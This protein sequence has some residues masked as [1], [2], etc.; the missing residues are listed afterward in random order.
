MDFS[1]YLD[2]VELEK[3]DARY[4]HSDEVFSRTIYINTENGELG[5]LS[6]YDLA[7]LGVP[8][9]RNSL[10]KGTAFAPDNIRQELYKLISPVRKLRVIDLGNLKSGNTYND[11]YFALKEIIFKLLCNN[12]VV[13]VIGGSQDLTLPIFQAFENYQEKISLVV[14]DSRIDAHGSSKEK[15]DSDSY[16]L[17]VLQRKQLFKFFN[18]GHQT[19]LTE[20]K[21]LSL[22]QSGLHKAIRLGELRENMLKIEPVLRNIEL[23]SFDIGAV[24]QSDAPGYFRP[25]PNGFYAEESCQLT[26]YSGI[27]DKMRVFGIFETNSKLDSHNHSAALVAQLIWFFIEGVE[28]RI[29]EDPNAEN[30]NFKTFIVESEEIDHEMTFYKSILVIRNIFESVKKI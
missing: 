9:E 27:S 12:M 1:D 25:N 18:L 11:T 23:L 16:L 17:D 24:R 20:Q 4:I 30:P 29:I 10:N 3:P 5:D 15:I 26:R 2:P 6:K 21:T 13:V 8:E 14:V 7:L 19:Y 28:C 22:V